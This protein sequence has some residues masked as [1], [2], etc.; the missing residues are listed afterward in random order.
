[1]YFDASW[2][3]YPTMLKNG[4]LLPLNDL[5]DQYAPALRSY[6][7]EQKTLEWAIVNGQ[8]MCL[9]NDNPGSQ[10]VVFTYREDLR[11]KYNLPKEMTTY[12]DAEHYL[13]VIMANEDIRPM[14]NIVGA[15][16]W[17]NAMNIMGTKYNLDGDFGTSNFDLTYEFTFFTLK[18]QHYSTHG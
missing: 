12:E 16:M 15:V 1:M 6:M 13:D 3:I 8:I 11:K 18:C 17:D 9:P 4:M 10:H 2:M 7:E 5:M 14:Y